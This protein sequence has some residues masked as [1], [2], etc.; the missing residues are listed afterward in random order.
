MFFKFYLQ[1]VKREIR[2]LRYFN[3][4]NII[5]LFEV[6]D[7]DNHLFVIIEYIDGGE[8]FDILNRKG[9]LSEN[10]SRHFFT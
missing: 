7:T 4:P 1:K 2:I 5:K 3:H 10:E 6:L 8:L 9:S